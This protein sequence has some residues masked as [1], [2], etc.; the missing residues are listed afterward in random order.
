MTSLVS[1]AG[2]G[3]RPRGWMLP[4]A[5]LCLVVASLVSLFVGVADLH[6][7]DFLR[8]TAT[9]DQWLNLMASRIPRTTAVLLAGSALALSG[10]LMQLLVRNKFVEPGTVGTSESAAAGLLAVTLLWPAAPLAV[11]M[12][13]AVVFAL[14]GTALF[15]RLVRSL[16]PTTSLIA[17]PLVGMMLA[18]MVSAATTFVAHRLDLLQT[19]GVWMAG[20]FS[21]VLRGRYEL[22]W[23]VA[24]VF[25]AVWFFADRFTV[26]SLG[27]AHATSLGL[28]HRQAMRLG[29]ALVS[30]ASAV[31]LVVVG[32]IAF[33]GLVVPNL[34]SMVLGDRL[35][36]SL[37]WVALAGAGFVLACDLVARTINFPYEIPVGTIAG[38]VG[39]A[40]FLVLLWK[41]TPAVSR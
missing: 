34:V 22:L 24:G 27:E 15:L 25:V 36:R 11:K 13:I 31:C 9:D 23:L 18:G 32:N 35:R 20:D 26:A 28:N 1:P 21:G 12:A 33:V 10:M 14:A 37:P 7:L 30:V 40:V 16:P 39:A 6:P 41:R 29:L 5:V 38:V 8:G 17:V 4:L 2:V 3:I 19:L